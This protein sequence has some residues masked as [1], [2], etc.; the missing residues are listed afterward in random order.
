MAGYGI[1]AM[2]KRWS[3]TKS[4]D[5][6]TKRQASQKARRKSFEIVCQELGEITVNNMATESDKDTEL[7]QP[8]SRAVHGW[9]P[10]ER[11]PKGRNDM[12][13]VWCVSP[14]ED[15]P[16]ATRLTDVFWYIADEIS[17][18]TGWARITDDGDMDFVEM[19]PTSDYGL[20]P[21]KPTHWMSLPEPP[22]ENP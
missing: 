13:D 12:I 20:P 7:T 15:E 1:V 4:L 14:R 8:D 22:K 19:E 21:W 16:G 17:P 3:S 11:A 6:L 9:Q 5:G 10:I 2:T 18:H